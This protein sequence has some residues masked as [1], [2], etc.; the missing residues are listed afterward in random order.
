M[1][2]VKGLFLAGQINGTTGYEEAAAQGVVAGLNAALVSGDGDGV[3]F[4]RTDSYIGVMIDDLTTRGVTE[5]YRM[6]TSR[7]EFRLS[8][9]I[10]NADDRL[11][12]L[13][14]R[15]GLIGP[16]RRMRR[17]ARQDAIATYRAQLEA[18]SL[19]PDQAAKHGVHLKKDGV[20][21]SAFDLLSHPDIDLGIIQRIWPELRAVDSQIA[22]RVN[23]DAVY[24]VY[25][26][27]QF[28]DI[29]A[30]RRDQA[31][32]LP[33]DLDLDGISGLSNELKA[34]LGQVRPE[35]LAEAARMEG[36]TPAALTLLAVQAKRHRRAHV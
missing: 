9:R 33:V 20:R 32:A 2:S 8:L 19:T 3:V 26:Q 17:D 18:H 29:E 1:R 6:F 28:S 11:G 12:A 7:S 14:D 23:S 30:Y 36:M 10:D 24:A 22:D 35:T 16:A 27:R 31:I 34:R 21:R 13:A 15:T 25:L 4:G 5:P